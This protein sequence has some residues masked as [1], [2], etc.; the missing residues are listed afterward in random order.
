MSQR[1]PHLGSF[2][3]NHPYWPTA[4]PQQLQLVAPDKVESGTLES[5]IRQPPQKGERHCREG[6]GEVLSLRHAQD[7]LPRQGRGGI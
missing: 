1:W 6:P 4:E 3:Q 5:K 7:T 2:G